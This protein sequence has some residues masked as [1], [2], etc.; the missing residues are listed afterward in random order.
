[1]S[2]VIIHPFP[3][4]NDCTVEV[5]E[6]MN[7]F[8]THFNGRNYL[9]MPFKLSHVIKRDSRRLSLRAVNHR[10][11]INHKNWSKF[12]YF[13]SR[14]VHTMGRVNKLYLSLYTNHAISFGEITCTHVNMPKLKII[15][16]TANI[17]YNDNNI[18][19]TRSR[20]TSYLPNIPLWLL[21]CCIVISQA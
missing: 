19:I 18:I 10:N 2:D 16:F 3:N 11:L 6:W 17:Q 4:F 20:R 9:S 13:M 12:R 8:I 21:Q 15:A 1:M 5:W 7:N 14:K